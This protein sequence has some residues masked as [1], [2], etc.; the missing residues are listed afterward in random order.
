MPATHPTPSNRVPQAIRGALRKFG[1]NVRSRREAQDLSQELPAER[2][3]LDRTYISGL[4]SHRIELKGSREG[5]DHL[6]VNVYL[7]N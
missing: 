3:D 1:D 5:K 4:G 6:D 2:A 7:K